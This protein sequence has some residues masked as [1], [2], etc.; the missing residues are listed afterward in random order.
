MLLKN[1][2]ILPLAPAFFNGKDLQ[3]PVRHHASSG[4]GLFMFAGDETRPEKELKAFVKCHLSPGETRNVTASLDMRSL[5]F[6]DVMTKSWVAEMGQFTVLTGL[7]SEDIV[8]SA[9]FELTAN[10][11]DDSPRRAASR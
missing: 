4:E 8:A 9:E 11:T 7:S 6:F 2:G 10:W 5:A 1:N 3:G